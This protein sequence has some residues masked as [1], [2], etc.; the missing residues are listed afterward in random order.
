V[1]PTLSPDVN[2]KDPLP[3]ILE[4]IS[5]GLPEAPLASLDTERERTP[6]MKELGWDVHLESFRED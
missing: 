1:D 6:F 4:K 5:A 3:I 2:P